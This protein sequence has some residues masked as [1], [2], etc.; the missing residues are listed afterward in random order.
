MNQNRK[1]IIIRAS[2]YT[3]IS[4]IIIP[5]AVLFFSGCAAQV[6][7]ALYR[8]GSADLALT[9]SLQPN[10]EALIKGFSTLIGTPRNGS[11]DKPT[12]DAEEI[13]K[14]LAA[15]PGIASVYMQNLTPASIAGTIRISRVDQFLALPGIQSGGRFITY[16]P[17]QG[18][19]EGRLTI[20]LN[21]TTGPQILALFSDNVRAYL[22]ALMAPVATGENLYKSQYLDLVGSIYAK[23]VADE[24]AAARINVTITFPGA[25]TAVR[26]GAFSG[27]LAR[28]EIPLTDLLVLNPP[29]H[30]EVSW[31]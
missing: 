14:S 11:P 23:P 9:V 6:E 3:I 4:T 12:L 5:T 29:L 2:I 10:M 19:A 30:Y 13:T 1:N 22:S 24:I 25:I 20:D 27:T 18:G 15:T 21:R 7:S 16:T 17:S 8:D 28:F 31:K 26:G